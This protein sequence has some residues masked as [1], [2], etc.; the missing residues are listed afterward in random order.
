M[1]TTRRYL[2]ILLP[3]AAALLLFARPVGAQEAGTP[4]TTQV[5]FSYGC[6]DC[7]PYAEDVLLPALQAHGLA[8]DSQF[9]DY[10]IPAERAFLL[11]TADAVELPRSIADSLYAF[12]PTEQ[13]TLVILGHVPP[14]LI[15]VVLSAPDLPARLVLWQPEMHRTPTEYRL[16]A[17]AGEVQTF[18]IDTPIED[19]LSQ[20]LR[21]GGALPVGLANLGALL[22]VVVVT[23][24]LDSVNPCAF[25]VILLLLA[26]LFTLRKSRGRI[27]QLGFVYIGMIFLVYFAIGLGL[28]RAVR[29]SDEPHFVARIGSWLL[30]GLGAVNLVE[31]FFPRF[32]LKLHMPK[33]AGA[34]TH[35]LIKQ[36]TFPTTVAAGLLVGL[37]TFPCSG[38]IYVSIITLLNAKT[39]L[40]WGVS[41]LALYNVLFVLPLIAILLV[42]GNRPAAKAWARWER[43]H[44]LRIR[45]WYGGAMVAAGAGMLAWVI[46][47]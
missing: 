9:H 1:T 35:E 31:Y 36:A 5:F 8:A 41:Y 32:P 16:W 29:F 20:A 7:W 39:T 23:G 42:V 3:A 34:R 14:D 45:L 22:P 2:P 30:I 21:A 44:A 6:A 28:L 37:C 27:L 17:W 4:E 18:P 19:A 24:L 12:V 46:P 15:D 33:I 10:T 11:E 43:E 38:G 40:A 26:F 25:A 47:G 13:G